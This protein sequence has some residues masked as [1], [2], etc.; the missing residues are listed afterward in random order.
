LVAET[1]Y[2]AFSVMDKRR[3]EPAR[4][5]CALAKATVFNDF[6]RSGVGGGAGVGC[7]TD[8]SLVFNMLWC[9]CGGGAATVELRRLEPSLASVSE[10]LV[11]APPPRERLKRLRF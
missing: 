5:S 8:A 4:P 9:G 3:H 6:D 10:P 2:L 1:W 7:A 11:R